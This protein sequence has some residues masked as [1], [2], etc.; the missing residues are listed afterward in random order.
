[1]TEIKDKE[2]LNVKL[3][4][5]KKNLLTKRKILGNH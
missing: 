3:Q 1:M 5:C 2:K 4:N